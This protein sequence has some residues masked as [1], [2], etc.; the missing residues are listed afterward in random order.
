MPDIANYLAQNSPRFNRTDMDRRQYSN[1]LMR[2]DVERL[3]QFNRQQ[4][5]QIQATDLEISDAQRKTAAGIVGRGFAA[6]ANSP[7]ARDTARAF[8]SSPDFQAAGKLLQLPLDQFTVTDQDT[9]D[10]IRQGAAGWAQALSGQVQGQQQRVQST[11]VLEDGTIAYVTSDGQLVRTNER[12]RNNLQ[13]V[14]GGVG[15]APAAFDRQ[16][17][18]VTP[19]S[20]PAVENRAAADR[21]AATTT[22]TTTAQATAERQN[23]QTANERTLGV[24]QVARE[25]LIKALAGTETGPLAG[26]VPAV[27]A[28]QQI[29]EGAVA[30]VAPVL[31]QLFRSAG[32]GVFTDRDQQLLLD[33]VPQRTDHPEA[34]KAKLGMI[35]SIIEAKLSGG[36]SAGGGITEAQYNALPSG[37]QYTAPDGSTRTKR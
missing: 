1:A 26:R 27:T 32:E 24:W 7:R 2:N 5:Q 14:P 18:G 15:G 12:A 34:A 20:T 28:G 4:D 3:P 23:A 10:V 6:I 17:G 35:D 25:G 8:I 30:A 11:Q 37:A 22:A 9:D 21:A 29:A 36:G 19:L 31:K 13:I 16:G 33:M